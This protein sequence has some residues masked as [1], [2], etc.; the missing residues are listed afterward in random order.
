M[1]TIFN[2][3]E[4]LENYLTNWESFNGGPMYDTIG[5]LLLFHACI[6]NLKNNCPVNTLDEM[7]N[8]LTPDEILFIKELLEK[9]SGS[10][11]NMTNND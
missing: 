2:N 1:G 6:K 4:E 5:M 7:E 3:F 9:I 8:F 10:K 11:I